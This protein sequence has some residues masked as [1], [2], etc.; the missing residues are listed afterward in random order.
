MV[1]VVGFITIVIIF[2]LLKNQRSTEQSK[3]RK[4][5]SAA[6][7]GAINYYGDYENKKDICRSD[8]ST[9]D[10]SGSDG[11]FDGGGGGGDWFSKT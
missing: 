9:Y 5:N 11:G 6:S 2:S 1:Y 7:N 4:N 8:D 10:G 3:F